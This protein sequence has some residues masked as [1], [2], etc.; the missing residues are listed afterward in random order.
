MSSNETN[1]QKNVLE[2]T[3]EITIKEVLIRIKKNYLYIL[4]K[5]KL[6]VAIGFLGGIIGF[7]YAYTTKKIYTSKSTFVLEDSREGGGLGQ[8]AGLASMVGIDIGGSAGDIFQGDNLIELYK[9]DMMIR[10][11][12]LTPIIIDTH[13]DYLINRYL[14]FNGL[15]EKW[16]SNPQLAKLY[17]TDNHL[18]ATTQ[19]LRDSLISIFVDDVRSKYLDVFKPDKKLS[20]I[21]VNVKSPDEKFSKIF[22]DLIVQ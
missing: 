21:E 17:F 2:D 12:L 7:F 13:K 19:R 4:S 8:Y 5:W 18:P 1:N 10:A 3:G 16:A 6:I 22:N 9:S 14:I 11:V 15:R 20:I